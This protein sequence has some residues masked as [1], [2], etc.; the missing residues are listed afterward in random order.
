MVYP[1]SRKCLTA[2]WQY[3]IYYLKVNLEVCPEGNGEPTAD[4]QL[5]VRVEAESPLSFTDALLQ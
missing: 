5:T 3:H 2:F 1:F 4:S